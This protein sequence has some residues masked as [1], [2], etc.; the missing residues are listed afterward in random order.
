MPT[1]GSKES[2]A[3][4]DRN[5][6]ALWRGEAP[7]RASAGGGATRVGASGGGR[8]FIYRPPLE[9]LVAVRSGM[10]GLDLGLSQSDSVVFNHRE[11]RPGAGW[12]RSGGARRPQLEDTGS[13]AARFSQELAVQ[14]IHGQAGQRVDACVPPPPP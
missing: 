11:G 4:R 9:S 12:R 6:A 13:L 5:A 7:S 1:A 2:G 3:G 10:S 14:C 8:Y